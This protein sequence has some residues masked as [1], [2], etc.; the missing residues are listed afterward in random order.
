MPNFSSCCAHSY[1]QHI[2]RHGLVRKKNGAW[3]ETQGGYWHTRNRG[4]DRKGRGILTWLAVHFV[5]VHA[6]HHRFQDSF[7]Y[8]FVP[9][10]ITHIISDYVF[11]L[12]YVF[13]TAFCRFEW[14]HFCY[15]TYVAEKIWERTGSPW[16]SSTSHWF[17]TQCKWR[18]PR[19]GRR[20]SANRIYFWYFSNS[21]IDGQSYTSCL[22]L[23]I[24]ITN[25]CALLDPVVPGCRPTC[26]LI[27]GSMSL[28]FLSGVGVQGLDPRTF[29]IRG[30]Q[31]LSG[32]KAIDCS[33]GRFVV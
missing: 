5:N 6:Y 30:G 25:I 1:V 31:I 28:F 18:L 27:C 12:A 8:W 3:K 9:I 23:S 16:W 17:H 24:L 11:S 29:L 7:L 20:W 22:F 19:R 10:C 32:C 13:P 33:M 21:L 4:E 14:F 26:Q 2:W 15:I